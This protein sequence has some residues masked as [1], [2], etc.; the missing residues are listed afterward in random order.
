MTPN[1]STQ[2]KLATGEDLDAVLVFDHRRDSINDVNKNLVLTIDPDLA[3]RS[4][5][6]LNSNLNHCTPERF[7]QQSFRADKNSI[8]H[9]E[10]K[11]MNVDCLYQP[12]LDREFYNNMIEWFEL[13]DCYDLAS[14]VHELWFQAHKRAEQEFVEYVNHLYKTNE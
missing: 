7:K 4:Y 9:L 6:K 14:Q 3:L 10:N 11:M 2:G 5:F 13:S 8:N 12:T 1:A